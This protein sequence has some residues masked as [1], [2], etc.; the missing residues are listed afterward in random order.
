MPKST[1]K[2]LITETKTGTRIFL[3]PGDGLFCVRSVLQSAGWTWA[4]PHVSVKFNGALQAKADHKTQNTIQTEQELVTCGRNL[5]DKP[6]DK[7]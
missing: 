2:E 6:G 5:K 4:V 3:V 1:D 7:A